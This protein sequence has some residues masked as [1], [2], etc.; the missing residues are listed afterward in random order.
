MIFVC[1]S[2]ESIKDAELWRIAGAP[3]LAVNNT[4]KLVPWARW[5][6][7]GDRDWWDEHGAELR[8]RFRGRSYTRCEQ[9]AIRY[10]AR[11]VKT[12]DG[13]GLSDIRWAVR[14]GGNSGYQALQVAYFLGARKITLLGYDM[15]GKHWHPDHTGRNPTAADF[16]SWISEFDQLADDLAREGVQVYNASPISALTCF[17]IVELSEV[18]KCK[19]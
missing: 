19:R 3:T 2:G 12:R 8:S 17:P 16:R 13:R 18:A 14:G 5:H 11:P 10:K 9:S 7:A 1:A 4:W 6:Y 15:C